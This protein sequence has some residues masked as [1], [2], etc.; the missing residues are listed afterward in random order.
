MKRQFTILLR[1]SQTIKDSD[2]QRVSGYLMVLKQNASK[3]LGS[4]LDI[5]EADPGQ[6]QGYDVAR[7]AEFLI[8]TW[9]TVEFDLSDFSSKL[10]PGAS[11]RWSGN[12]TLQERIE[13]CFQSLI[14][15]EKTATSTSK[16]TL[17]CLTMKYLVDKYGWTV[18]WSSNL[19]EHLTVNTRT[20]V[21]KIYEHKICLLHHFEFGQACPIPQ[22][23]IREAL[24][25]LNL[26]FP[27]EDRPTQRYLEDEG[28][29][30]HLL[31]SCNR[32][33]YRDLAHYRYWNKGLTWLLE[34]LEGEPPGLKQ[35]VLDEQHGH[36]RDVTTFWLAVVVV[37][38][39]TLG[40]GILSTVFAA[41]GYQVALMQYNLALAQACSVSAAE[42][43]L[44]QYCG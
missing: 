8:R 11:V 6:S 9:L 32:E 17:S 23:A 35:F 20:K 41:K 28:R 10:G 40:F 26:L 25:T 36:F 13:D 43:S 18:S 12:G 3:P 19:T 5:L 7:L 14:P 21:V 22:E 15:Y 1:S 44:L 39:L 24:D 4:I 27:P 34:V 2:I 16:G 42:G 38:V 31:G 30:F 29:P 37:V 33:D